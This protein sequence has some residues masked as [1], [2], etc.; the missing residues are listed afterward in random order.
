M[1]MR[2]RK[3]LFPPV[4]VQVCEVREGSLAQVRAK[5]IS[6]FTRDNFGRL[7]GIYVI[8]EM[9]LLMTC[10]SRVQWHLG[11]KAMP[12]KGDSKNVGAVI[13]WST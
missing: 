8:V 4:W 7:F 13:C 5:L 3:Q 2:Q 10:I 11:W 9:R 12:S 1:I 6:W